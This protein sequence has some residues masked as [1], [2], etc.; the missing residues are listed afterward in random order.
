[1][2]TSSGK[3]STI[4]G[5]ATRVTHLGR[6]PSSQHGMVNMP[7]YHAS[8][9]LFPDLA[10]LRKIPG[11][12]DKQ[13]QLVYGRTGTPISFA[14]EEAIA[15][16]EHG[17][18]GFVVCSGLAAISTAILA[19]VSHGDHILV[20]DAVYAPTRQFCD[21]PLARFGV[22]T[23]YYDPV[24]GDGIG[25]LIQANTRL[26]YTESP[27]SQTFEVQ[28]LPAISAVAHQHDVL[29]LMD[30]TWATPLYF[31]PFPHGVD[32]SIHAATKYIVGHADAMLG[33]IVANS[34]THTAIRDA[35]WAL[36][37]CAGPDDIYLAL[38]GLRTLSTRLQC[39]QDNALHIA[40]W[41]QQQPDVVR[42]LHPGLPD[43]PGHAL[44]Q[45]DFTG[46][47]GLFSFLLKPG[48]EEA[49]AA[50]LDSMRLFG[51][52]FSWGGY[53]SLIIPANPAANRTARP[54]NEAG[55]LIRVHVGL[56]AVDD[57]LA[58]LAQGLMR[59]HKGCQTHA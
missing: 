13:G 22:T 29:V 39:H 51:M 3:Q 24:I 41:L 57:L 46:C 14:L 10:S 5:N 23:S 27:G 7:V 21:G 19:F 8:T 18:R 50:M 34:K 40:R 42:V 20:A 9:I 36:G 35:V 48:P 17:H 1:M 30:N 32:V 45:R 6:D 38:R 15:T 25:D 11:L 58:D 43:H 52:G 53:E 49:L 47:S 31:Q 2:T 59:Y 12:K 26:I 33:M 37:Q 44:W 54:W 56:E 28:D 4:L 16:L 55:N